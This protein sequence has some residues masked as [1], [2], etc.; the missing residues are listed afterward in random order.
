MNSSSNAL[1]F[2]H[3]PSTSLASA[4]AQ[5]SGFSRLLAGVWRMLEGVGQSRARREM[6]ALAD[7]WESGKPELAAQLRAACAPAPLERT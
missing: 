1:K 5:A 4:P 6:L 7:R 3:T 2:P